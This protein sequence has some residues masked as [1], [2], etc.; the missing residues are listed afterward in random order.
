MLFFIILQ[1]LMNSVPYAENCFRIGKG[2]EA[3]LSLWDDTT[4]APCMYLLLTICEILC[5]L[6]FYLTFLF[7]DLVEHNPCIAV[8]VL[9]KLINSPDMDAYA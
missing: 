8:E 1:P 5:M 2:L 3:S 9:S 6:C 4:E 7:Q